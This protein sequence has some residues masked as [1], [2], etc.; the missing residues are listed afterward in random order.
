MARKLD[1]P[2]GQAQTE[3]AMDKKT[4]K[5][6]ICF[7]SVLSAVTLLVGISSAKAQVTIEPIALTGDPVPGAPAGVVFGGFETP[8]LNG[9]G[10][11]AFEAFTRDPT[12]IFLRRGVW[13]GISGSLEPVAITKFPAPGTDPGVTFR[14]F[15]E[16]PLLNAL[17][18]VAFSAAITGPG[19]NPANSQGIWAG[20]PGSLYFLAQMGDSIPSTVPEVFLGGF[21][22]P[23]RQVFNGA[24]EVAFTAGIF[25]PG[26]DF[27][28]N[29]GVFLAGLHGLELIARKGDPAPGTGTTFGSL[30]MTASNG[31]GDVGLSSTF[32]GGWLGDA[33]GLTPFAIVGDSAPGV[34]PDVVFSAIASPALNDLGQ[35]AFNGNVA[36]PGVDSS[37]N[38][39]I[40]GGAPG[41]LDLVVR[42]GDP[43]PGTPSGVVFRSGGQPVLNGAG[44][45]AFRLFLTGP[46]VDFTN[47]VGIWSAGSNG[48][49]LVV[50]EGDPAPGTDPGVFFSILGGGG[51]ITPGLNC[52]GEV[53]FFGRLGGPGVNSSNNEG[54][55]AGGVGDLRL[56]VRKGDEIEVS[57]EDFRTVRSLL[58]GLFTASGNQ[59][60]RRSG[61]NDAG[62]VA[63]KA[64]FTDFSEGIFLASP[65]LPA[66]LISDLI[67]FVASLGLRPGIENPLLDKLNG[68]FKKLNDGNPDNDQSATSLLSDFAAIV[69]AKRKLIGDENADTLN[70]GAEKI[71]ASLQCA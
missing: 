32:Q 58:F 24:G 40:W 33:G 21:G 64:G 39:G 71:I 20:V 9:S 37:N 12:F 57:S 10:E 43:A 47:D 70:A 53:V 56:I 49:E 4:H 11:V 28:N 7:A 35:V 18:E 8:L 30:G 31:V 65:P 68:A 62:Q 66:D 60:G 54:I 34:A 1:P 61:F 15:L 16:D 3:D 38:Q 13:A 5:S 41:D 25:G 45:V 14:N 23:P 29:Q 36:G 46:D 19:I 50:R 27:T 67:D 42:E 52:M 2:L 26:V 22:N 55:W 59:D 48:V 51:F 44:E 69:E 6:F 17:G 63:F